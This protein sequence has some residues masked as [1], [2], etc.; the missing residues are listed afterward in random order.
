MAHGGSNANSNDNR[1]MVGTSA[2]DSSSPY[3]LHGGDHPGL[4]LVSHQLTGSNYNTWNRD[5]IMALTAKNKLGFVDGSLPQPPAI[6]L[7]F[8]VWNRC[9]SIVTSWILNVVSRDIA[10]SPLCLRVRFRVE[11]HTNPK[12]HYNEIKYLTTFIE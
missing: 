9:N 2:E 10:D 7:L 1:V 11:G 5:M 8:V 4:L 6:D 12:L 3:F